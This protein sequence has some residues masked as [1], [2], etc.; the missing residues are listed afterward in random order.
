ML[1]RVGT[2]FMSISLALV[3][4][5]FTT[6]AIYSKPEQKTTDEKVSEP[7]SLYTERPVEPK[8]LVK[9]SELPEIKPESADLS[10]PPKKEKEIVKEVPP[11]PPPTPEPRKEPAPEPQ[12]PPGEKPESNPQQQRDGREEPRQRKD[13][14]QEQKKLRSLP[15]EAQEKKLPKKA[16][17]APGKRVEAQKREQPSKKPKPGPKKSNPAATAPTATSSPPKQPRGTE[18]AL[19]VGSI[20][21]RNE[22]VESTSDTKTLDEG[23]I[24]LPQTSLPWDR[25]GSRNVYVVGHRMGWPNTGSWKLFYRLNELRP[26]DRLAIKNSRGETYRYEVSEKLVVSPLDVWATKPVRGR[27][28]LTLQT[29]TGP[30]FSKRLIVRADRV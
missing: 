19:S 1:L 10:E 6:T 28:L 18:M 12:E 2:V 20:G 14:P 5:I 17:P 26:G 15:A 21:I 30:D 23:L 3:A 9:K 24:H 22:Q 8:K 13:R 4:T 16:K 29:C 11:P 25:A 27:D 7:R